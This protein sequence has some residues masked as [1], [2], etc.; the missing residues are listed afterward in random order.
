MKRQCVYERGEYQ[1]WAGTNNT[2]KRGT[3][4]VYWKGI[5]IGRDE[6]LHRAQRR[7]DQHEREQTTKYTPKPMPL[8]PETEAWLNR[9]L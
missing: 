1:V 2:K 5:D 8:T 3:Y 6:Y 7:I 4:F 9:L